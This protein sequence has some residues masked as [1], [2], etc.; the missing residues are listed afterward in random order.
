M[1]GHVCCHGSW[2]DK[3]AHKEVADHSAGDKEGK[4]H[5]DSDDAEGQT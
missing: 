2:Q 5:N 1:I 3:G 4:S